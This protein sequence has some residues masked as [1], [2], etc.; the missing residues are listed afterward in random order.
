MEV[1]RSLLYGVM[2]EFETSKALIAACGNA[3]VTRDI[4]KWMRMLHF[5][6]KACQRL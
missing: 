6:L 1:Q 3:R 4:S 2:G 5:Q